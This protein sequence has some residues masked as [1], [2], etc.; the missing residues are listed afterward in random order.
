MNG[1]IKAWADL[2]PLFADRLMALLTQPGR[3]FHG[4]HRTNQLLLDADRYAQPHWLRPLRWAILYRHAVFDPLADARTNAEASAE[5][6]AEHF[7]ALH[8]TVRNVSGAWEVEVAA[9]I[10]ACAT[11]FARAPN[12]RPWQHAFVDL[13]CGALG[14]A[15]AVYEANCLLV[16]A[17]HAG[18]GGRAADWVR[19]RGMIL[20]EALACPQLFHVVHQDWESAARNNM[21]REFDGVGPSSRGAAG[22]PGTHAPADGREPG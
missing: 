12:L 1:V 17:E 7:P 15:P 14:A 4:L 21:R 13:D 8:D 6:W 11:P 20:A 10:L 5:L 9:A 19:A 2:P 22:E 3:L 18:A 16:A